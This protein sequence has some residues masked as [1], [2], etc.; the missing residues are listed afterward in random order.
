MRQILLILSLFCAICVTVNAHANI[1]TGDGANTNWNTVANWSL[2]AVPT[3]SC[4][5]TQIYC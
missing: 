3:A 1:G 4:N 5:V 2:I